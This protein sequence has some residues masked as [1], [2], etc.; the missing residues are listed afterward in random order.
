LKFK[1][2]GLH[3]NYTPTGDPKDGPSAGGAT[4]LAIVSRLLNVPVRSDVGITGEIN[5]E[6]N[7]TAIGGVHAKMRGAKAA[8][9]K[10]VLLPEANAEDLDKVRKKDPALFADGFEA[11]T[12]SNIQEL[13]KLALVA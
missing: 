9:V 2:N 4:T 12:V 13:M 7:I 5:L 10:L 1:N 6:G 11:R 8:G 3:V